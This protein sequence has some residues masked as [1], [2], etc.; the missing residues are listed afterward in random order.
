MENKDNT[1]PIRI[2]RCDLN[3]IFAMLSLGNKSAVDSA[4]DSVE[5]LIKNS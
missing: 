1:D 5:T 2:R 3:S 4:W